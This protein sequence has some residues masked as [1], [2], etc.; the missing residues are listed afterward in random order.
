MKPLPHAAALFVI[1]TACAHFSAS[2]TSAQAQNQTPLNTNQPR[3]DFDAFIDRVNDPTRT[4]P[5]LIAL[6]QSLDDDVRAIAQPGTRLV[7]GQPSPSLRDHL[8]QR[9][10]DAH[11]ALVAL[12]ER[13]DA[14]VDQLDA[15]QSSADDTTAA[16][17]NLREGL[18]R[19]RLAR[20]NIARATCQRNAEAKRELLVS[21]LTDAGQVPPLSPWHEVERA[22][23]EAVALV[24]GNEPE[25][26]RT[27][28]GIAR[29]FAR[30]PAVDPALRRAMEQQVTIARVAAAA[31]DRSSDAAE[32]IYNAALQ[33]NRFTTPADRLL[34]A[35]ALS[36]AIGFEHP[37]LDL[38]SVFTEQEI[39]TLLLPRLTDLYTRDTTLAA[40]DPAVQ[41][42]VGVS[43][44]DNTPSRAIP[45]L[46][47]AIAAGIA[48]PVIDA[49]AR[50]A[51]GFG[52][53]TSDTTAPEQATQVFIDAVNLYPQH[54]NTPHALRSIAHA[55]TT[56]ALKESPPT[57]IS[58]RDATSWIDRARAATPE[59]AQHRHPLD[60]LDIA[61]SLTAVTIDEYAAER[62]WW[63][64]AMSAADA[65]QVS[66]VSGAQSDQHDPA[67]IQAVHAN[68]AAR[69]I[70]LRDTQSPPSRDFTFLFD[71]AEAP[72]NTPT[73]IAAHALA[74]YLNRDH[75]LALERAV[76]AADA[77]PQHP[78]LSTVRLVG[79]ALI[80]PAVQ[81][82]DQSAIR[83][84]IALLGPAALPSL[85]S[86]ISER[87]HHA[88][89]Q[90]QLFF[91]DT[92]EPTQPLERLRILLTEAS[93]LAAA[94]DHPASPTLHA[95]LARLCLSVADPQGALGP[96]TMARAPSLRAE[97]LYQLGDT[98]P[99][100]NEFRQIA[101]QAPV[102]ADQWWH[103]WTRML[104]ILDAINADNTRT[105]QLKLELARLQARPAFDGDSESGRRIAAL[106]ASY[107]D[108]ATRSDEQP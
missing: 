32:A 8:C 66:I 103:A 84:S 50:Y 22:L 11:N 24:V 74:L 54:R 60:R 28:L 62:A 46:H 9:H 88:P 72:A 65:L 17:V 38:T 13:I 98:Q 40:R 64:R 45:L 34:A 29:Q 94:Q 104:Q 44:I 53:L 49:E 105:Q 12:A 92:T 3:L 106:A 63:T 96:A 85:Q 42:A 70:E 39:I 7:F 57:L 48:K 31:M 27:R 79:E 14:H 68:L 91:D 37:L 71:C 83:R 20:I 99:A 58:V 100:F 47:R 36:V 5:Q 89:P 1:A 80:Y 51:L 33:G 77:L 76:Q 52:L 87:A 25:P 69:L 61:L 35:E 78:S 82:T 95:D 108:R 75:A 21:A 93:S 15:T 18:I 30:D 59:N 4:P 19:L 43:I 102:D 101:Q 10:E 23:L 2:H 26:A 97:A 67:R 16:L 86:L 55:S 73:A 41:A 56:A 107:A 6:A 81:Q 90:A